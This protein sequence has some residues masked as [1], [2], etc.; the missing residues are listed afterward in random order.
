MHWIERATMVATFLILIAVELTLAKT[1]HE[2]LFLVTC[3]LVTGLGLRGL[4]AKAKERRRE[5]KGSLTIA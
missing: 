4:Y 5:E 3:V 1:K 2:A